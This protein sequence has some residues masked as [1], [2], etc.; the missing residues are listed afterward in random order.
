M[1][2]IL[3]CCGSGVGPPAAPIRPLAWEPPYVMGMALKRQ[4]K[5]KKKIEELPGGE[6]KFDLGHHRSS[7]TS[8]FAETCRPRASNS[9]AMARAACEPDHIH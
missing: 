9:K 8:L 5:K 2:W 4:K 1:A 6:M 7:I 3:R